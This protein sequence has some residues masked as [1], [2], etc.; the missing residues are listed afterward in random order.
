MAESPKPTRIIG[1]DYGM[2][3]IG[4]SVSDERKIIAMPLITLKA[5]K[6]SEN[7]ISSLLKELEKHER[8][9][10]Y[11]VESIV[12]GLPL[13]MSGKKGLLADEVHHFVE[14]LKKQITI[15]IVTWDERLTSVQAD[16]SMRESGMTRKKR[17]QRSDTVAA[18]I[19]LQ[20]YLDFRIRKEER[21]E[22]NS[23]SDSGPANSIHF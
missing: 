20:N 9:N 12:I 15:P 21:E 8:E 6:K 19:I 11:Q 4:I 18:V 16:R 7:T 5:E 13:L 14:L 22:G 3:R 23:E 1:I 17:A 10:R 2:A